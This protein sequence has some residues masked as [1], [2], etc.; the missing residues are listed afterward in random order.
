MI[1][2]QPCIPSIHTKQI[3]ENHHQR[4]YC[5]QHPDVSVGGHVIQQATLCL[6]SQALQ[7]VA[8]VWNALVESVRQLEIDNPQLPRRRHDD[9][10][11]FE[12][13]MTDVA[14]MNLGDVRQ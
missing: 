1:R 8:I 12:I 14:T 11:R 10:S 13:L 9:V 4:H 6:P 3:H 2:V 5:G 7:F